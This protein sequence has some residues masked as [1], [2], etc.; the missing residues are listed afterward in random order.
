MKTS[1]RLDVLAALS[2]GCA[3]GWVLCHVSGCGSAR[4]DTGSTVTVECS[5]GAA[6]LSQPGRS[7]E[8]LAANV[9][10]V[11]ANPM[12]WGTV[13]GTTYYNPVIAAPNA[14]TDG[15]AIANCNPGQTTVD[16]YLR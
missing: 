1:K 3:A 12:T 10:V 6:V 4:A 9:Y 15:N 11:V 16:F 14:F 8:D 13:G 7:R 5:A 2:I